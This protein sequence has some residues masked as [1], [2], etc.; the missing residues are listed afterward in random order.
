MGGRIVFVHPS[1]ELYGA[2]QV[3]LDIGVGSLDD[4]VRER[5]VVWLPT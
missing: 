2:D 4:Q 5:T 1:D 3:F